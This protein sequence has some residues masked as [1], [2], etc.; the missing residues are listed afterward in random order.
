IAASILLAMV[1]WLPTLEAR[2]FMYSEERYEGELRSVLMPLF[3]ANWQDLNRSS[4]EHYL[5]VMYLYWGL[6]PI[7]AIAW[8]LYRRNL[9]PYALPAAVIAGC[10][11]LVLH[12]GGLIYRAILPFPTLANTAQ[13]YNFCEGMVPMAA[14]VAA[15]GVADFL[16]NAGAPSRR[17]SIVLT[18]MAIW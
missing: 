5:G 18:A 3:V 16:K 6:P 12:P 14:L 8:A 13:S 10:L 15:I 17:M 11:W 4:T 1:Q 9:R 7:F 2:S